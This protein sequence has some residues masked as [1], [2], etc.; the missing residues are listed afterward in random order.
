MADH[1]NDEVRLRRQSNISKE[2]WTVFRFRTGPERPS[3]YACT[4]SGVGRARFLRD[5]NDFLAASWK[6]PEQNP[7]HPLHEFGTDLRVPG[8]RGCDLLPAGDLPYPLARQEK[9]VGI[10]DRGRD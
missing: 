8:R 9:T 10:A 1:R 2:P 7:L 4:V 5:Q 6:S 3:H